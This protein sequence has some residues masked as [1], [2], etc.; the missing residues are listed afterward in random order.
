MKK[1]VQSLRDALQAA[2]VPLIRLGDFVGNVD[3]GGASGL[4]E[5]DRCAI[6]L[7]VRRSVEKADLVL[8]AWPES[9]QAPE[10]IVAVGNQALLDEVA[11]RGLLRELHGSIGALHDQL[12]R[13][14]GLDDRLTRYLA[15]RLRRDEAAVSGGASAQA[16]AAHWQEAIEGIGDTAAAER[17]FG[18][19]G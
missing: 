7:D 1:V 15:Y 16:A 2:I 4:G 11:R 13:E 5:F 19:C 9:E 8:A 12:E 3:K 14:G 18:N 17:G 6:L 10:P